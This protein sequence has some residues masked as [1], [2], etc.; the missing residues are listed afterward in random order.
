MRNQSLMSVK[1]RVKVV[2][3]VW[4]GVGEVRPVA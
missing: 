3:V 1:G 4:V 2:V